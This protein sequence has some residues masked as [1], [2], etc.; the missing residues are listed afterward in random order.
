MKGFRI[1]ISGFGA[2]LLAAVF[3]MA[4]AAGAA[5]V[6]ESR[7]ERTFADAVRAYDENRLADAIAGWQR[8]CE[9]LGLER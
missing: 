3:M 6:D 8:A 5:P 4:A 9:M 1:Q 2:G 7:F